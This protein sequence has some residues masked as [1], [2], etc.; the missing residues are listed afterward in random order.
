MH[1]KE[2]KKGKKPQIHWITNHLHREDCI[3]KGNEMLCTNNCLKNAPETWHKDVMMMGLNLHSVSSGF[4]SSQS[5]GQFWATSLALSLSQFF[6]SARTDPRSQIPVHP[7]TVLQTLV[8]FSL[9]SHYSTVI[10]LLYGYFSF[11]TGVQ[12]MMTFG[13]LP[14]PNTLNTKAPKHFCGNHVQ[15]THPINQQFSIFNDIWVF[16]LGN[17][18]V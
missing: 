8:A 15:E 16:L 1:C 10:T 17:W 5:S 12:A 6:P 3:R 9:N 14:A 2:K 13:F 18:I 7:S 11:L 4:C